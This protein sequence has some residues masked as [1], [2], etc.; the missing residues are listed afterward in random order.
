[1]YESSLYCQCRHSILRS[2]F[3]HS[4]LMTS[5]SSTS[6]SDLCRA[7]LLFEVEKPLGESG[8]H[9]LKVH[10]SNL[11]GNNKVS[12]TDRVAFA[13][14]NMENI[15]DS[16]KDPLGGNMWWSKAEEPFQT[17]ATCIGT[18]CTALLWY[19]MLL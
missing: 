13:D 12:H 6:G 8:M 18:T 2:L 14:A 7:L 17:L 1:M 5:L 9:W 15:M 16:A 11:C 4:L 19:R 10:L 3:V